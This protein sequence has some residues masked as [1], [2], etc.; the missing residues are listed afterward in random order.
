MTPR[1][2]QIRMLAIEQHEQDWNGEQFL[3]WLLGFDDPEETGRV[4][5]EEARRALGLAEGHYQQ[6]TRT[7]AI[8]RPDLIATVAFVQGATFAAAALGREPMPK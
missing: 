4:A 6:V 1:Y 3:A 7:V 2:A 8:L 5:N